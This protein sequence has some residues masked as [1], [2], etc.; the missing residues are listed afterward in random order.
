MRLTGLNS[1][2]DFISNEEVYINLH[3]R[4][5][6]SKVFNLKAITIPQS[7]WAY[8]PPSPVADWMREM[9]SN[10]ADPEIIQKFPKA[11]TFEMI[12][13]VGCSIQLLDPI[14]VLRFDQFEVRKTMFGLTFAGENPPH[15]SGKPTC[16]K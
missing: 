3:D 14:P 4:N 6:H 8:E 16:F 2:K 11:L 9:R 10:L 12:L 15:S 5:D 1:E 13:S 7:N